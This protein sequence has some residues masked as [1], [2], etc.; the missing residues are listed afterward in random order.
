MILRAFLAAA[1][2]LLP[3]GAWGQCVFGPGPP[4]IIGIP[5]PM[6]S[7]AGPTLYLD[8]LSGALDSRVTFTRSTVATYFDVAGAM[9]TAAINAPRFDYDPVTLALKGLLIEAARTNLFLNSATLVTQNVT[10][11]ATAYTLSFY[12]TGTVTLTGTSTAGPLTGSG[13]TTRVTQTFTPTAGTLTATVSGSVTNAQIEAGAFATS[14][15]ATTG[16]SATRAA[17]VATITSINTAPWFNAAAG[18]LVVDALYNG[19][20]V[21][22]FPYLSAMDDGTSNNLMVMLGKGTGNLHSEGTTATVAQWA[23]QGSGGITPGVVK[24]AGTSFALNSI[25]F[26]VNGVLGTPDTVATIPVVTTLR[27]GA[28]VAGVPVF[29]STNFRRIQF[30]PRALSGT[31]LQGA[32]Q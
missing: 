3:V 10:T 26:A 22:S 28:G 32:T 29:Q 8:F 25:N 21:T 24:K 6:I 30:W 4:S 14:Y 1:L 18:T 23:I 19:L 13:A 16:A 7:D 11:T 17:D 9:Q 2:A 31:E 12:G 15:F 20:T 27:I 5:C